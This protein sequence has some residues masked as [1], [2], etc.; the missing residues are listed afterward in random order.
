MI[1]TA[2]NPSK[3]A[4][5]YALIVLFGINTLNF[6][7]RLIIAAVGEPI[8]KEFDLSDASLGALSTAFV[9]LYAVVGVPFGRLADRSPRKLILS[10]GVFAW[11]VLT[12]ASGL[13]Q[14]FAQMFALRL[15]VGVGEASCAP[16]S[17][18]LI[19][20]LYPSEKRGRAISI[21]MLGLP[22]GIALS[23]AVSGTI[24]K[25]YGWRAAFLVA[26]LPGI[27]FAFA[28][29]LIREPTRGAYDA[30]VQNT[31][32][33]S[34]YRQILSSHTMRWII[35]SGILHNFSLYAVSSFLTPYLMRYHGLDIQN[36]GFAAMFI[37][38]ILTLPGLLIGGVVGDAAKKRRA[39]GALL[40]AAIACL[41][42]APFYYF[43]LGITRNDVYPFVLLLGTAIALVYFYYPIVYST[44]QD[45]TPPRL[46]GTAISIYFLAMYLLGGA[47]GPW[48]VGAISDYF[49]K[50]AAGASGVLEFSAAAL[51]PFRASGLHSAM[52]V[53]PVL[54]V[55]LGL[56]LYMA[57]QTVEKETSVS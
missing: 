20:D 24:A 42:A 9:L 7:D 49:T 46:R 55:V 27:L 11:S 12:A 16:A 35:V 33:V 41:L 50:Q 14:N 34:A 5:G 29:L 32:Q 36:A 21:F 6:F 56:V 25:A 2:Q 44:I 47:L 39:N 54:S 13:A 37:N 40:V 53:V 15:G 19:G 31:P 57:S 17:T 30:A 51:E 38:G 28:A 4:A 52:Y 48:V 43:S 23:F 18:S 45:I 22:I 3:Y 8:R 1:A 26:G 10:A